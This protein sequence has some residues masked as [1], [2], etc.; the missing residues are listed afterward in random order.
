[1]E[2]LV[3]IEYL[4]GTLDETSCRE[5]ERWMSLSEENQKIMEDL[6]TLLFISSRVKAMNE[7][8]TEQ[9]FR[10]FTLRK[11]SLPS[12]QRRKPVNIWRRVAAVA[13]VFVLLLVSGTFATL[14]YLDTYS[15]PLVVSTRLGEKAQ[16]TLPDGSSV[17]LNACSQL[18]YKKAFLS[19]KR[20]T[21][22]RGEAYFEVAPNRLFPFTVSSENTEIKVLGTKFNVRSNEDEKYLS[23]TLIEGSILFSDNTNSLSV[24]LKPGE[25]L[26]FDKTAN[27]ATLQQVVSSEDVL[28]WMEGK[29]IFYNS[30]LEEIA[31]SLERYYNV[32]ILFKN[33]EVKKE[34]FTAEFETA[35]NIYHILSMLE[36]TDR[37]TYEVNNQKIIISSK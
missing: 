26:L 17:W 20:R 19:P 14:F 13:A 11:A 35:D 12:I 22:L 27:T 37:F 7:V 18:E 21:T 9:A 28:G 25:K 33:E 31:Q 16:V 2:K 15:E 29:L 4:E 3:L 10:E 1:M 23:T 6:Y 5:V 24:K 8:D 32:E 30:S 34:R 36:L